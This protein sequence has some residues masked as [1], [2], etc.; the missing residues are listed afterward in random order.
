MRQASLFGEP[1]RREEHAPPSEVYGRRLRAYALR[2]RFLLGAAIDTGMSCAAL[3]GRCC[4]E[5]ELLLQAHAARL[6]GGGAA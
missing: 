1:P 4:L 2:K 3:A 5:L 6:L